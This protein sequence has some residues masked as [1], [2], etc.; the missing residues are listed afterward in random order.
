MSASDLHD[1][2]YSSDYLRGFVLESRSI[3]SLNT[4]ANQDPSSYIYNLGISDG[5]R[6]DHLF[7]F[8][9]DPTTVSLSHHGSGTFA[10]R[11]LVAE[12]YNVTPD[13]VCLVTGGASLSNHHAST[14]ILLRGGYA[15]VE[16]P[17]YDP[18][19]SCLRVSHATNAEQFTQNHQFYINRREED[20]FQPSLSEIKDI[21]VKYEPRL[22]VFSNPH[23]P[24]GRK[25]DQL[26]ELLQLVSDRNEKETDPNKH[27]YVLVDE[28]SRELPNKINTQ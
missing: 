27:T 5:L 12:D 4:N 8:Q 10:V 11:K 15:F 16:F 24:S 19:E 7:K 13:H 20:S 26:E 9:F 14:A 3:N 28:V 25:I 18:L 6:T 23:N 17:R 21:L 1:D 2:Y 22:L